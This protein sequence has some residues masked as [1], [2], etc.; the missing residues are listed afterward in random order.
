MWWTAQCTYSVGGVS[1][2]KTSLAAPR[3]LTISLRL[4]QLRASWQLKVTRTLPDRSSHCTLDLCVRMDW[5]TGSL[6]T[7]HVCSPTTHDSVWGRKGCNCF[8]TFTYFISS[9][10]LPDAAGHIPPATAPDNIVTVKRSYVLTRLL[11]QW[12]KGI[13]YI[14]KSTTAPCRRT[15]RNYLPVWTY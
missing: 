9:L 8:K 6:S 4:L 2:S 14:L 7:R 5:R 3:R 11:Q 13:S 10:S 15:V 1:C 12:N